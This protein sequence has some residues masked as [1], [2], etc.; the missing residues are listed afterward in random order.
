MNECSVALELSFVIIMIVFFTIYREILQRKHKRNTS[1]IL[2]EVEE[3]NALLKRLSV[4]DKLTGLHNR[5]KIDETLKSNLD[6]FKRYENVFSVMIIDIDHF[7]KVNDNH[8][9]PIG[10]SV[11]KDFAK[12]LKENA[13]ITDT[14]GRWGGEEF[15]IIASETDSTG[16]IKFAT[17]LKQ[18]ISDY[19]FEKVGRI[20]ASFGVTQIAVGDDVEDIVQ[21]ADLALYNAKETGRNKVVCGL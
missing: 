5:I 9:H 1:E 13:R 20:T 16:A 14:I 17:T 4:T 11:L 15:M 6:M 18:A 10:D 2:A 8:G 19:D 12:I 21:R 3:K 7:K